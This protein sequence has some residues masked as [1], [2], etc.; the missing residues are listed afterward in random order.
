MSHCL[1]VIATAR[2]VEVLRKLADVY[3]MSILPLDVT[4]AD[5]IKRCHTEVANITGGK[6][7]ILI[8][9]A[10]RTHT[11]PATDLDLDAV[12]Q[13]FET[14][15][16]GTMAMVKAFVDMLIPAQ[17]LIINTA[18][19]SAVIPY[20]FG[21]AYTASKSAVVGYSRTLR[22]ELAPLGVRVMVTMTGSTKSN[23]A[24]HEDCVLP[25][26]SLY[27]QAKGLFEW[28]VMFS[29]NSSS[30]PTA[31]YAHQLVTASLKPEVPP[32]FRTWFGRPDWFWYGGLASVAWSG[33]TMGEWAMDTIG[34]YVFKVPTLQKALAGEKQD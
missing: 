21:A 19:A 12:R 5:S 13:T 27:R 25:A 10:G 4:N 30:M 9:N 23:T 18:S 32:L 11:Y 3:G 26:N 20:L 22:L 34:W 6:L 28:R 8:N 31:T 17:G 24:S 29:Q 16:F 7:D 33:H 2:N 1:H 15:V 14:N